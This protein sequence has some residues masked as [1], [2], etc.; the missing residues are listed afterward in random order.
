MTRARLGPVPSSARTEPK[1]S[2]AGGKRISAGIS[3]IKRVGSADACGISRG[4]TSPVDFVGP[5]QQGV[6][7]GELTGRDEPSDPCRGDNL[8]LP[9]VRDEVDGLD[10]ETRLL[11]HRPQQLHVATALVA[12]VEVVPDDY[13]ADGEL[14]HK[15]LCHEVLGLLLGALGV[16]GEDQDLVDAGLGQQLQL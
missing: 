9:L 10:R 8:V 12:K 4:T 1:Y 16:K 7:F 13:Y 3:S 15:D 11:P 2:P 5:A 14:A 6:R